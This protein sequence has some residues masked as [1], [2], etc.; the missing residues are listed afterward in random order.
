MLYNVDTT[1]LLLQSLRDLKSISLLVWPKNVV[2]RRKAETAYALIQ[3]RMDPESVVRCRDRSRVFAYAHDH[4]LRT[5]N[6]LLINHNFNF[7]AC[8]N[9]LIEHSQPF[10]L[11]LAFSLSSD[12]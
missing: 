10:L 11:R 6:M 7:L 12:V 1:C 2:R 4:V 9:V 8:L 3:R 5:P